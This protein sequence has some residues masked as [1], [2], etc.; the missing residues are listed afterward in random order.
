VAAALDLVI[1][2]GLVTVGTVFELSMP[3]RMI[4]VV[5]LSSLFLALMASNGVHIIRKGRKKTHVPQPEGAPVA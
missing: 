2:M 1:M 4:S 5:V 3:Y